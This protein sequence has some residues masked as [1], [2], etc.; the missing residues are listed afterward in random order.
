MPALSPLFVSHGAPDLVLHETPAHRFLAE[1]GRAT[2]R[3]DAILVATAHYETAAPALSGDARPATIHDFGGFDR[4]LYGMRYTAPGAPQLAQ[5]AAAALGE[6]GI[7]AAV[8]AGRG[9]DHGTWVP[10]MLMHP[11]ANVPVVQLSVQPHL[12]P[13]HHLAL[14]R[15]LGALA[16]DGILVIGSGAL[17]HNLGAFFRGGFAREDAAEPWVAAFADWIAEK[18]ADGD[19]ASLVDYRARAPFAR[20]NHPSEEHLLP[21][22]VALGAAGEGARGERI[23]H[24]GE[25]GV[26]AM[27]VYRFAA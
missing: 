20:E 11:D 15:A 2:A 17:T 9:Y 25:F 18:A 21:L 26:L 13:G 4:R 27:D 5:R 3:P 10:L 19:A 7:P 12:G 22:F 16:D 1:L 6:A 24:S 14:G 23:H 8:E